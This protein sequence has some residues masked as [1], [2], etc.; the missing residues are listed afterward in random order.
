MTV[1]VSIGNSD[2]KLTQREWCS[3]VAEV[4]EEI[5]A[6]ARQI[7]GM[8]FSRPDAAWQNACWCF[9]PPADTR[10]LKEDLAGIASLY[11][12][13]SIAWAEA[14]TTFLKEPQP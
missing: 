2:D 9:E 13:D 6:L 11:R 5:E 4:E 7:H 10:E 12:Q 3:F 1:Y 8:W 14:T